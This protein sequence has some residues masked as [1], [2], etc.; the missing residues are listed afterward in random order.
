MAKID[1]NKELDINGMAITLE[2]DNALIEITK[3]LT[4]CEHKGQSEND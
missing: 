1:K 2:V 4:P 3:C